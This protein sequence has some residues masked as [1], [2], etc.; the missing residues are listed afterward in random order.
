M[1]DMGD[2]VGGM[3]K[4]L[5]VHPVPRVTIAGGF[6]KMVKLAQGSLDL[7]S[8]RS[9]I[10][11]VAL[12]RMAEPGASPEQI[13]SCNTAAEALSIAGPKLAAK[14]AES[15]LSTA[16]GSL[17]SDNIELDTLIVDRSGQIVASA[18]TSAS[19]CC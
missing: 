10:D 4:Y 9:Q 14:V 1:L 15:A 19:E 8:K 11:F 3:L 6:G 13:A 16:L 18:G 17:K 5:R 2:F 12:A 7:H